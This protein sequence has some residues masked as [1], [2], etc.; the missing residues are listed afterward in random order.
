[1]Y[2]PPCRAICLGL[3]PDSFRA[4]CSHPHA[5]HEK[6]KTGLTPQELQRKQESRMGVGEGEVQAPWSTEHVQLGRKK[7]LLR[8]TFLALLYPGR[9]RSWWP[10][11]C[12]PQAGALSPAV[13]VRKS[14]AGRARSPALRCRVESLPAGQESSCLLPGGAFHLKRFHEGCSRLRL[15]E[16]L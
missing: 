2:F 15:R 8:C 14:S 11:G 4:T 16:E 13:R 1:M 10:A 12:K 5:T 3:V 7:P 6:I 9:H